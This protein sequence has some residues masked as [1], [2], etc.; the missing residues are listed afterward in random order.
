[1]I[2]CIFCGGTDLE[3][4]GTV[5]VN[6]GKVAGDFDDAMSYIDRVYCRDCNSDSGVFRDIEIHDEDEDAIKYVLDTGGLSLISK[7]TTTLYRNAKEIEFDK[8]ALGVV[9]KLL[10]LY[11]QRQEESEETP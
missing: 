2:R 8:N 1:M 10:Y 4:Q 5:L 11:T 3:A 7:M 9:E 6:E